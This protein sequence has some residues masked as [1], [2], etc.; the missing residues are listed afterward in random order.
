MKKNISINISGIIFH[1]EEDGY[2]TLRKY[3]DSINKYFG[4]FEDSS[5]IL[6]DIESR[7]AEIFLSRL[8]DGKQVVTAEDVTALI[9]TMGNVN[10]FKAAE[11]QEFAGGEA[12]QE[13]KQTHSS[14]SNSSGT[15]IPKKLMRDARRKVLGGVC[16]G[17]AN[18]FNIDPVWPRLLFALL[19][20]G[21]YGGLLIVYIIL[22][23]VLPVS[24]DL[25]EE[26][27]VKKMF[28]DPEKKVIGGVAAGVAAYFGADT[29]I[30]RV[31]FVGLTFVGGL[32]AILYII[33][34]IALPEAKTITEKMQMQGEPVTL[35]NIE[36]SVKRGLNEKDGQ[37]ESTL[38]KIILFPFRI[39]AM[40]ITGIANALGPVFRVLIDVLRV[41]IGVFIT[42]LGVSLII[43]LIMAFGIAIGLFHAPHWGIFS[44]WPIENSGFPIEAFR[45]SFPTWTIVGAFLVAFIPCLFITLLGNSIIAKKVVFNSYVG[46]TLFILFFISAA[47][48]SI[49]IPRMVYAF[50]E[51]GEHKVEQVFDTKGKIPVLKIH[52]NGMDEY[53]VTDLN[54]HGYSGKELKLIERFG[55]QGSSRKAA[56]ENAQMIEYDVTQTDSIITF[57]SNIRFK[58][59]AKFR[60]QR[61]KMDLYVPYDMPFVVEENLWRLININGNYYRYHSD[62]GDE[63]WK[64]NEISGLKCVSCP[65]ESQPDKTTYNSATGKDEFGLRDFNSVDMKGLFDVRIQR[66]DNYA[67]EMTGSE[68]AKKHY[69]LSVEGETLVIDYDDNREFWKKGFD[70]ETK[71]RLI[72]TM[73][74]LRD[75][76]AKGAG[77]VKIR[78]FDE[79]EMDISLLGAVVAEGEFNVRSLDVNMTGATQLELKGQGN[80][81]EADITGASGLKAYGFETKSARIEAHGAS[82]ARVYVTES[83]EISKGIASTVSH[84]GDPEVIREN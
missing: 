59:D 38:A 1:I 3:L 11:E 52:E 84:R 9:S 67:V 51:E 80:F 23:I 13:F 82:T 25:E 46:W 30:I 35:S 2:D 83:L 63:T 17:L 55:A 75:L 61:L 53:N 60:A 44:D 7:I 48:L 41:M 76:D 71:I 8:N 15:S 27:T 57:D 72:I 39:I 73:P 78:G 42:L 33:F 5:E 6:A 37:E 49:N 12:R 29:S 58:K 24:N 62:N 69:T 70:N 26:P 4:S 50:K 10:D 20:L 56:G 81:L 34:W 16:A 19:V 36:S 64:I 65:E 40:I 43:S 77:D 74:T 14:T 45:N 66:G 28:R 22:W 54:I 31:V 18:Y 21:S 68:R 32:G 47:F 79:D